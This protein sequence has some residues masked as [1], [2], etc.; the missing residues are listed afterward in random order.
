MKILIHGLTSSPDLTGIG[1]YTGEMAQWLA[2]QGYEVRVVV[3]PPYYP[4]WRVAEG[5][6]NGWCREEMQGSGSKGQGQNRDL[7]SEV[8]GNSEKVRGRSFFVYRCPLWV[9]SKLSGLQRLLQLGSF[10]LSSFPVMLAQVVWRPDVV[11]VVEPPF[12]CAPQAWLVAMLSGA[13]AWLHIQDFEIDAAFDLGILRTGWMKRWALSFERFWLRR[14]DRISTISVRMYERLNIKGVVPDRAVLFPNWVD[15]DEIHPLGQESLFRGQLG[16]LPSQLVALYSGT[17][18]EKQGLEIVLEA[19]AKLQGNPDIQFVLCGDGAAKL[20]L[21]EKYAGLPNVVWLPLQP[22]ER[23]NDLLNMADVHLL[24]Q[25]EDVADLVMPSKLLGMLAS[26]RP[27]LATAAID[28]QVGGIVS[29]CGIVSPPGNAYAFSNVLVKLS[30]DPEV[31]KSL[32]VSG[33]SIAETQ[34]SKEAVLRKFEHELI[35]VF[36]A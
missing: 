26:G 23:L 6:V 34:F 3:A 20:R 35:E 16:F 14:F 10:V 4:Q 22:V 15:T 8:K 19:A 27:V 25:R 11:L 12:F 18:G 17:M 2:A 32:G 24:P 21:Q 28:T 29:Q 7:M 36:R 13:K 33:R 30:G 5:Y 31:R 1:K 9:P